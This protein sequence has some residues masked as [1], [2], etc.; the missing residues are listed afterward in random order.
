MASTP[1]GYGPRPPAK[2]RRQSPADA[3]SESQDRDLDARGYS[4]SPKRMSEDDLK[5]ELRKMTPAQLR[6][7]E[8]LYYQRRRDTI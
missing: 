1:K 5:V 6:R 2:R 8:K 4:N 3:R 7:M